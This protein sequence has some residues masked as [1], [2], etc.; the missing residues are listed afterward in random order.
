M[1]EIKAVKEEHSERGEFYIN[2]CIDQSYKWEL[3]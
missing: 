3:I 1:G 2:L